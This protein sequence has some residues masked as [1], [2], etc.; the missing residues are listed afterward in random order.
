[1]SPYPVDLEMDNIR[2]YVLETERCE[3]ARALPG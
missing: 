3:L 1:M 2:H